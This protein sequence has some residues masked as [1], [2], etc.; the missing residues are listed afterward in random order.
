MCADGGV[1]LWVSMCL[2]AKDRMSIE[3]VGVNVSVLVFECM[4]VDVCMR[5]GICDCV[6]VFGWRSV[7]V[8]VCSS[9]FGMYC[10]ISWLFRGLCECDVCV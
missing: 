8:L 1:G 4:C 9:S 3:S 6:I 2:I 10:V 5:V 7:C